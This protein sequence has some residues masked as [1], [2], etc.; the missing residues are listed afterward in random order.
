MIGGGSGNASAQLSQ[1]LVPL[2]L[3]S[4]DSGDEENAGALHI[5]IIY[6]YHSRQRRP[7]KDTT[8]TE[9]TLRA[10]STRKEQKEQHLFH[11]TDS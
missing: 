10:T 7:S 8:F 9:T 1:W 3:Q 5:I 2:A 6:I 4:V 11:F